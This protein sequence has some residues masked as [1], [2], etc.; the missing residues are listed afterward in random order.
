MTPFI[1]LCLILL[2]VSFSRDNAGL[3]NKQ[4]N[5]RPPQIHTQEQ[6]DLYR[7]K[8][9]VFDTCAEVCVAA[10]SVTH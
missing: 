4:A 8:S 10:G 6:K 5:L 3:H 7:V 9:Q 1:E 2:P